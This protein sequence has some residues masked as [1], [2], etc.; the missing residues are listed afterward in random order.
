MNEP[1]ANPKLDPAA[2]PCPICSAPSAGI[3]RYS[4]MY[5]LIFLGVAYSMQRGSYVSCPKCARKTL[6]KSAFSPLNI[7][8]AN[9]MWPLAV[10]PYTL[11]MLTVSLIPGHSASVR[12]ALGLP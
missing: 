7:L 4:M 11:I 3:K 5:K 8:T 6:L 10:V 1:H 2:I 9:V 12:K